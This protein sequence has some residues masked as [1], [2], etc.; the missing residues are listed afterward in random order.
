MSDFLFYRP[1][2][3]QS[4]AELSAKSVSLN[5]TLAKLPPDNN[6][7]VYNY[8]GSWG[9]LSIREGLYN[10]FSPYEDEHYIALVIGGPVLT[11]AENSFLADEPSS[12][13][14]QL[15][16]S[17]WLS[18]ELRPDKDLD[19]PFALV[20]VNKTSAAVHCYTDLMLFLPIFS[21]ATDTELVIGS[22]VD[23]VASVCQTTALDQASVADFILHGAIT[24]PFTVYKDIFQL[25]P[26]SESV[27]SGACSVEV[28]HYWSPSQQGT[29]TSLGEQAEALLKSVEAYIASVTKYSANIAQ[30]I[31][32]GEDSRV[33]AGLLS[34]THLA[35]GQ[36]GHDAYIFTDAMNKEAAIAKKAADLYGL[37]FKPVMRNPM[38]YFKILDTAS[39][40]T[41]SQFQYHHSHS[42]Q[43]M[44]NK[45]LAGYQAVF[46]GFSADVM[47][48]AQYTR[49]SKR[50]EQLRF[51]PQKAE[52]GEG[53]SQAIKAAHFSAEIRH[54]INARRIQHL[55]RVQDIKPDAVH[56]WFA[57]WP[58]TMRK[59]LP[60]LM[61]NR[62]LFRSYEP[63]VSNAVV[64]V[65]A[66]LPVAWRLN[67]R[68]FHKAFKPALYTSRFLKHSDGRFPYLPWWL[69][70]PGYTMESYRKAWRRRFNK[71]APTEGPWCNWHL[72]KQ[73]QEWRQQYS[74]SYAK[75]LALGW[76]QAKGDSNSLTREQ[77]LNLMQL[78]AVVESI[79]LS[80]NPD[81]S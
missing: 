70:I 33:L 55:Q 31:S 1:S 43:V 10:G 57:I 4:Q 78:V 76:V 56:E 16:Y 23:A 20:V 45:A 36:A 73:S 14:T 38:H 26:A 59:A 79:P 19:G 30:F 24:Y 17:R 61:A 62:R 77:Q 5:Q 63:F 51:L 54:E 2:G 67:R 22:H 8:F 72:L 32:A 21:R 58:A 48:K 35:N 53:H 27:F 49:K 34:K 81:I 66:N 80:R 28:N 41:G 64:Q 25:A 74:D 9:A 60:N 50:R 15:V 42:F 46:G 11:F 37:N 29:S 12:Q 7:K 68:I 44:S 6:T 13:G 71:N 47:L 3:G 40:L 69:N 52:S 65:A 18:G 39:Q 75:A